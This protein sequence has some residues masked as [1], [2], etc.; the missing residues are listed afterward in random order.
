MSE[1]SV[2]IIGAG[3]AGLSTGCYAQMNGYRSR[4]FEHHSVSGGVV[5]SWK[6]DGYLIDGGIHFMMG[7]K[8]AAGLHRLYRELGVADPSLY[9]DMTT[10]GRFFDE[11]SGRGVEI[12]PD[13]ERL[14]A[15]LKAAAPDDA[16]TIDDLIAGARAMQGHDL[17]TLGM[18]KPPE[19]MG[20][21]DQ[22][23]EMWQARGLWKALTGRY[24]RPV[25]SY[26]GT[27]TDPW[28]RSLVE[29]LFMPEVPVWFVLMLLGALADGQLGLLAGGSL[30]FAGGIVRR[31]EELGGE[32]TTNATVE[33]ILVEDD[34]AVG[35]RRTDGSVHHADV[36]VS[37]ADG[38][39]TIFDMLGGRYLDERIVSRYSNWRL[40]Q[41]L[42]MVS[43]GVRREFPGEPPFGVV[44][45]EH[46]FTAAGQTIG[47]IFIRI[48]NYSPR[49]A[50]PGKSVVQVEF[51]SQWE[52]WHALRNE[53]ADRYEAEKERVAQEVL[54]RLERHYPGIA[55][56]VEVTDV[57]TPYTT[58]RY[59]RN[60][61]GAWGGWL[62]TPEAIN[63]RLKR[64]LPGLQ[65]FYMAG[66]WV[67]P[68]GG[69]APC[70]YSGRHVAQLLCRR[71]RRS[72]VT[73]AA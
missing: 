19:L 44:M 34:R 50:P 9:V 14:A 2:I 43:F 64:T 66:Q 62:P 18:G 33:K 3:L 28:L 55:A 27:M 38:H 51:E 37:A 23:A 56:Q 11:S 36:I 47:D 15:D 53:G 13:L 48:F 63:T 72:F 30:E 41:P 45:L 7:Y 67:M 4:I 40:C 32:I 8:P 49:F 71:D 24:A 25:A 54:E 10:Y 52:N 73:T 69:V 42:T 35:V 17:S 65:S 70:L 16:H 1:E 21:L 57:V 29:R 26:V 46:P 60:R 12:T 68:G 59:T 22:L 61:R 31:Y 20:F 39:S 58:W 5:A 6:R